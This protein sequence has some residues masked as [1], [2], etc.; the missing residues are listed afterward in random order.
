MG[1]GSLSIWTHHLKAFEYLPRYTQGNYS[2]RAAHFASGL[3]TWELNNAMVDNDNVTLVGAG[4]RSIGA[5]GGWFASGGHG[6]LTSFYGLA[7][8]QALEVH[9]VTADGR[10][11]VANPTTNEDLFYAFRGGGGSKSLSCQH[12]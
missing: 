11:V 1:A 12:R 5:N 6:I 9:A 8:D 3:E 10:F 2:G 4:V 7:A